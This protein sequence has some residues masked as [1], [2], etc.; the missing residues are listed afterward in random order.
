MIEL[1]VLFTFVA[2]GWFWLD[3]LRARD[4]AL[5]GARRAC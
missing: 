4:V 2:A 1:A 3:S 5:D